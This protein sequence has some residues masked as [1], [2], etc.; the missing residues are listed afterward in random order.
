MQTYPPGTRIGQYEIASRPMMGGMGVVYFALDHGNDGRPVALKT[1]QPELLPD[2]AARD[3]FLRE[4]TTWIEL[5]AHPN[6]VRAYRVER[7]GDGLEM[8]LVLELV[9]RAEGR[10]DASLRSWL[11]PGKPLPVEQTLLMALQIARG[12]KHA[13]TVLPKFVHRDLKPENVLVGGDY[14]SA[15]TTNRVRVTDFGLAGV[16]TISR[17]PSTVIG[18]S[19][20]LSLGRTQL[21]HGVVGTPRYM[22]PEQWLPG[23]QLDLRADIYSFG[24]ML[25]EMLAGKVA[26]IGKN[27]AELEQ[28]HRVG[29]V[30][31]LPY[32]IPAEVSKLV[33]RCLAIKRDERYTTW[34][35][36]EAAVVNVY[37]NSTGK[38]VPSE[39]PHEIGSGTE[40]VE[41]GWSYNALGL[42]YSEIGKFNVAMQYFER[43]LGIAKA[44]KERVLQS[45]ALNNI[46]LS[47]FYLGEVQR[48][49]EVFEQALTNAQETKNRYGEG[50]ALGNLGIAYHSLGDFQRSIVLNEQHLAIMRELGNR[51]R[52]GTVLGNLGTTYRDLGDVKRAIGF[53]E[54]ALSIAQEIRDRQEEARALDNLGTAYRMLGDVSQAIRLFTQALVVAQEIGVRRLEGNI[55]MNLGNAY[56]NMGDSKQAIRFYGQSLAIAREVGDRRGE[57]QALGNLGTVY[58]SL[59]ELQQAINFHEQYLSIAQEIGD[60]HGEG[61]AL[62]NLGNAYATLG[63]TYTA[64]GYFTQFHEI[65]QEIGD[66]QGV[67]RALTGLGMSFTALGFTDT[68]IEKYKQAISIAREIGDMLGAAGASLN[69]AAILAEQGKNTE[70]LQNA[71][72]AA[73]IFTKIGHTQY[74]QAAQ[75]LIGQLRTQR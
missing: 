71:E 25:Y 6:I 60:R 55:L 15:T 16:L 72:L 69:L 42:S 11:M 12:M 62:G 20:S 50:T 59:G 8:Y 28:A 21:T 48:A 39:T 22:A 27:L 3:R 61:I 23:G 56:S 26:V 4:G 57:G 19:E 14:L 53:Y 35:E 43:V 32:G 9:A 58:R 46:G 54:Q 68:A 18:K 1:F 41:V 64:L 47:H 13:T 37:Q 66:Q 40:R 31:K 73:Q 63:E 5:G 33:R 44:E 7:F 36:V 38:E 24:C 51:A 70:A 74:A 30:N 10:Q 65:T 29:S 52:E 49:I 2:R 75:R 45:A 34:E 67:V 17:T